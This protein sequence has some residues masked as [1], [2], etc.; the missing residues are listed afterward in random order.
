MRVYEEVGQK[1]PKDMLT[2]LEGLPVDDE[3]ALEARIEEFKAE[4]G[5]LVHDIVSISPETPNEALSKFDKAHTHSEDEV[6]LFLEGE[7]IFD[8]RDDDGVW[9]RFVLEK[10]DMIVVPAGRVHRFE[11]T[12]KKSLKCVRIFKDSSGWVPQYLD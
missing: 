7:G 1:F 3:A 8:L 9:F 4:H 5:Y 11:P 10:G 12:F 2:I 6:R